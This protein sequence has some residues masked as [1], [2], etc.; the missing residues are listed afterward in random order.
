M[1]R[2]VYHTDVFYTINV[3]RHSIH[4]GGNE[5]AHLQAR[6]FRQTAVKHSTRL[7][8]VPGLDSVHVKLRDSPSL[9]ISE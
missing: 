7:C 8:R 4:N 5:A 3:L 2:I 9:P 6:M 1:N